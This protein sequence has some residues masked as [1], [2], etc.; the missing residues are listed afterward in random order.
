[1]IQGRVFAFGVGL[2]CNV[3]QDVKLLS[4]HAEEEAVRAIKSAA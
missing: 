1:M 2:F 4:S 3:M